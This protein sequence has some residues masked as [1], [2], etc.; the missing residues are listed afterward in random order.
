MC[1]HKI[2]EVDVSGLLDAADKSDS[3]RE[4]DSIGEGLGKGPVARKFENPI[5]T[6]LEWAEVLLVVGKAGL[7]SG[8]H[9]VHIVGVGRDVIDL[10]SD[11]T[12][13]ALVHIALHIIASGNIGKEVQ[14]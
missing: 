8:D 14:G 10:N 4:R 7:G 2:G 11:G 9:V 6:E 12:V 1:S 3:F 5:L 13:D